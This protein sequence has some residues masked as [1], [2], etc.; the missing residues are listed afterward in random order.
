MLSVFAFA[1][2]AGADVLAPDDA[3]ASDAISPHRPYSDSGPSVHFFDDQSFHFHEPSPLQKFSLALT[4]IFAATWVFILGTCIGSFLNVVIYRMPA[5]L[6]LGKPKS[7]CPG[8]ETPLAARD[9]IPVLGW[10]LLK[11]R[12]RYCGMRISPRYPII[13]ATVGF[14]FLGLLFVEIA[15]GGGNLP[16]RPVSVIH[17][18]PIDQILMSGQWDLAG[19]YLFHCSWLTLVLATVMIGYDGHH[20][21]RRLLVFG[22]ALAIVAGTVWPEIRPVGAIEPR[23]EWLSEAYWGL[24]WSPPIG[25][26]RD[27]FTTGFG[28]S[29]L[30][31]GLAGLAIGIAVVALAKIARRRFM[32]DAPRYTATG[33]VIVLAGAFLG[34]QAVVS[35]VLLCLPLLTATE[36]VRSDR[37]SRQMLPLLFVVTAA[38]LV[39]WRWLD[40]SQ[41]L[42]GRAPRS[43][44]ASQT[45]VSTEVTFRVTNSR[46]A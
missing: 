44:A 19:I 31:D 11:G 18:N 9:N 12:C 6:A 10:L 27:V 2:E 26:S 28:L 43:P 32:A 7:R 38:F 25:Y 24:R 42:T 8:C 37:L 22:I 21:P 46:R 45:F 16:V 33:H 17:G 1:F 34:W 39:S 4:S 14:I 5:G 29:G 15:S 20:P 36:L 40:A 3:S 41:W 35:L 23:P 30:V 13:E